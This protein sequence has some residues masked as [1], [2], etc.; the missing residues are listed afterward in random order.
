MNL[1]DNGIIG[2]GTPR[3]ARVQDLVWGWSFDGKF[4]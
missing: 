1:S 3:D 4:L 2:Q